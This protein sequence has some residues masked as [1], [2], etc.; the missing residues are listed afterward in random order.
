MFSSESILSEVQFSERILQER[1]QRYSAS[2]F[3]WVSQGSDVSD[4]EH[5]HTAQ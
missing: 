1:R 3:L 4:R 5:N 2:M